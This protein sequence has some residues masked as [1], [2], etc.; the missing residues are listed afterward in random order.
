MYRSH[1]TFTKSNKNWHKMKVARFLVR[2]CH[3]NDTPTAIHF[4]QTSVTCT[5]P[6]HHIHKTANASVSSQFLCRPSRH[7]S[8]VTEIRHHSVY[9]R[10]S[11][12]VT[13]ATAAT[14]TDSGLNHL[15]CRRYA[16]LVDDLTHTNTPLLLSAHHSYNMIH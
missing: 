9:C 12:K 5:Q 2:K 11:C 6:R 14:N 3:T 7:R 4:I 8:V 13:M 15:P 10:T 16:D 1:N